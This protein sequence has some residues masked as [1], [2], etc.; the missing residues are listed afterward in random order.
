MFCRK[1]WKEITYV[2][3]SFGEITYAVK[4]VGTAALEQLIDARPEAPD[5]IFD[6]C[7]GGSREDAVVHK[8][9]IVRAYD[10]LAMF[11]THARCGCRVAFLP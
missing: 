4:S 8:G 5:E 3:E 10:T 9:Q 6:E 2:V 1:F 11:C 7:D